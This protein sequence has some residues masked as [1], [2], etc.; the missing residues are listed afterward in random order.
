MGVVFSAW[1]VDMDREVAL[2]VLFPKPQGRGIEPALLTRFQ[3]EATAAGRLHHTHIVPVYGFGQQENLVFYTMPLIAGPSLRKMMADDSARGAAPPW[4]WL[5]RVVRV[6]RHIAEALDHAHR[7]G[8]THRDVKPGNILLDAAGEAWLADFGLAHLRDRSPAEDSSGSAPYMAPEQHGGLSEPASDQFS[9]GVTLWELLSGQRPFTGPDLERRKREGHFAS[10]RRACPGVPRDLAR[11]LNRTLAPH[12]RDRYPT[13][14]ALA[15]DLGR[16]H[17]GYPLEEDSHK[18]LICLAKWACRNPMSAFLGVAVLAALLVIPL[19]ITWKQR[20]EGLLLREQA[21][22]KLI[23]TGGAAH[24]RGDM[25]SAAETLTQALAADPHEE[26][27][28]LVE[29]IRCRFA[30]ENWEKLGPELEQLAAR[31]DLGELRPTVLL[32]WGDF[33]FSFQDQQTAARQKALDALHDRHLLDL[34]DAL[35]AEGL[36]AADGA[37]ALQFFRKAADHGPRRG[38]YH[39]AHVALAAELLCQGYLEEARKQIDFLC[40]VFPDDPLGVF[41][42]AL[43]LLLVGDQAASQAR[44]AQLEPILGRERVGKLKGFLGSFGEILAILAKLDVDGLSFFDQTSLAAKVL[45][46]AQTAGAATQSLG[47]PVPAAGRL[48]RMWEVIRPTMWDY[49]LKRY[50]PAIA[51]LTLAEREHPE[52]LLL[53]L[54]ATFRLQVAA[55][56]Y[57]KKNSEKLRPTLEAMVEDARKALHAPTILPRMSYRY[58]CHF[59]V[60]AGDSALIQDF[61]DDNPDRYRRLADGLGDLV[62]EGRP[63][64]ALREKLLSLL[65]G[66]L[67]KKSALVLVTLWQNDEERSRK[68]GY[69]AATRKRAQLELD[70]GNFTAALQAAEEVHHR[71]P[72]EGEMPKIAE[73]ARAGMR[74][75]LAA[76]RD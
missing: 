56:C 63:F 72:T 53:Y 30:L 32:L 14:A 18:P 5:R 27:A 17:D 21:L 33:L 44:I 26:V 16:F 1:Q 35:Y 7:H 65:A 39:R 11:I 3:N 28:L 51:R 40:Q 47:F 68:S 38:R 48:F 37:T 46:L 64:P 61:K 2:K 50:E 29:R 73:A 15:A 57:R 43:Q 9:L 24:D 6:G 10:L 54:R 67:E 49:V 22:A 76:S 8:I 71:F 23:A 60:V 74:N 12:P 13:A 55:D 75:L 34:A 42:D 41:L 52:A 31:S 58:Q 69:W 59:L 70:T 20:S 62:V 19:L 4:D 45:K 36:V 66:G 25:A